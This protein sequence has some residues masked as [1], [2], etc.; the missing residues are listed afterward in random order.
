MSGPLPN[1]TDKCSAFDYSYCNSGCNLDR[2]PCTLL[3]QHTQHTRLRPSLSLSICLALGFSP[4]YLQ[5][6]PALHQSPHTLCFSSA[7]AL[8]SHVQTSGL[9]L[10]PHALCQWW[11]ECS[12]RLQGC[13]LTKSRLAL[14]GHDTDDSFTAGDYTQKRTRFYLHMEWALN[15]KK[16]SNAWQIRTIT[17]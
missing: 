2:V 11:G 13:V 3:S 4:P 5:H 10:C 17:A 9:P 16:L 7:T 12:C 15:Q 1:E 6:S 8:R 14:I